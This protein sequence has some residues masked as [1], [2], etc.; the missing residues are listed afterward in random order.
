[1]YLWRRPVSAT[2]ASTITS[3]TCIALASSQTSYHLPAVV[4]VF[5]SE[6]LQLLLLIVV[7]RYPLMFILVSDLVVPNKGKRCCSLSC[8]CKIGL[9]TDV[10]YITKA[11]AIEVNGNFAIVESIS[12]SVTIRTEWRGQG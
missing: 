8:S 6:Q 7:F 12:S 9:K 3:T 11:I 2:T 1:M 4:V 5:H 10:T